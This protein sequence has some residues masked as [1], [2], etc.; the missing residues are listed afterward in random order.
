MEDEL[1]P[2]QRSV[3]ARLVAQPLQRLL[4]ER[5]GVGDDPVHPLLLGFAQCGF[6][7][8]EQAFCP[9]LGHKAVDQADAHRHEQVVVSVGEGGVQGA[10]DAPRE[11]NRLGLPREPGRCDHEL[12]PHETR[13][14]VS[15][16]HQPGEPVGH[17]AQ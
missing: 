4:A 8:A 9:P 1:L 11:G 16:L 3:Q 14:Q 7:L 13:D 2:V 5:P 10:A 17:L 6:G 12:I 15:C